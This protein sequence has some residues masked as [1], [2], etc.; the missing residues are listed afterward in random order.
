MGRIRIW[1][2]GTLGT[3]GKP[4]HPGFG[5]AEAAASDNIEGRRPKAVPNAFASVQPR[6]DTDKI[7]PVRS[8]GPATPDYAVKCVAEGDSDDG[9]L[10]LRMSLMARMRGK[11]RA[12][13]CMGWR[14]RRGEGALPLCCLRYL[15]FQTVRQE[16]TEVTEGRFS[17]S[18][19]APAPWFYP[20]PLRLMRLFAAI[21]VPG[22]HE[23]ANRAI[24][25]RPR[26]RPRLRGELVW[27]A[28][29]AAVKSSHARIPRATPRPCARR[30][31]G[32]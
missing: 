1:A 3:R 23:T 2:H 16:Q 8:R 9:E 6:M 25:G 32:G 19:V 30:L 5:V 31:V 13:A 24:D 22:R 17:P 10:R 4:K 15:L 28:S 7:R 11:I 21:P 29:A 18:V 20:G 12:V 27:R 14:R 26:R